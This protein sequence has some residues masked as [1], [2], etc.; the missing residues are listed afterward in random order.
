MK[1]TEVMS[2]VNPSTDDLMN[3]IDSR[4]TLVVLAAKRARQILVGSPVLSAEQSTKDVTNALEEILEGKITYEIAVDKDEDEDLTALG[5]SGSYTPD[6]FD[7]PAEY[8]PTAAQNDTENASEENDD[9]ND[10]ITDDILTDD[11]L[12]YEDSDTLGDADSNSEGN[13][14]TDY[15]DMGDVSDFVIDAKPH[16]RDDDDA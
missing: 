13:D 3:K 2:M 10:K 12:I 6:D 15:E 8:T 1:S 7:T 5:M 4:Y 9:S 16:K 14:K 11:N